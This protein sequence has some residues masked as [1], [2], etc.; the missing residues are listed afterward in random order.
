MPMNRFLLVSLAVVC[1]CL[2]L[3]FLL[4]KRRKTFFAVLI[5]LVIIGV[6]QGY[7]HYSLDSSIQTCIDRACASAGLPPGCP[8]AE[9]GCT[10]WSGLS[11]F[12]FYIVGIAQAVI[13]I[14][15]A[16]IMALLAA[17]KAGGSS[18]PPDALP[19]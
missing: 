4:I 16:G 17:R 10:E 8:E 13:F 15:G 1:V 2:F 5:G 3:A 19:N 12:L 11:V 14:V 6:F 7:L 18:R 9:F